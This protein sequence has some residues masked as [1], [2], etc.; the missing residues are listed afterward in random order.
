M[1]SKEAEQ[2]L[3]QEYK[4]KLFL[5]TIK[6]GK[7]PKRSGLGTRLFHLAGFTDNIACTVEP[8]NNTARMFNEHKHFT[9]CLRFSVL[10]GFAAFNNQKCYRDKLQSAAMHIAF[11]K[12]LK[13][14]RV[15]RTSIYYMVYFDP[16][17]V[18]DWAILDADLLALY[19]K[20]CRIDKRGFVYLK[21][22]W[23]VR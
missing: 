15:I 8:T 17:Q 21:T 13:E 5:E 2:N 23:A 18:A 4:K 16:R 9:K 14:F 19:P 11:K 6:T 7:T 20:R 10:E 1:R 12:Y 22:D 3:E